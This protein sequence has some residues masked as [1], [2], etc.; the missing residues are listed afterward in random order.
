VL[1]DRRLS[2]YASWF[3]NRFRQFPEVRVCRLFP[4]GLAIRGLE[5]GSAGALLSLP[6][7]RDDID[8]RLAETFSR[9]EAE[10]FESG[11]A[12]LREERYRAARTALFRGLEAI[13]TTAER[14][15]ETAE[16]AL[17]RLPPAAERQHLL[18]VLDANLT[19]IS[20]SEVKEVAGFL[21]PPSEE[22]AGETPVGPGKDAPFRSYL[23]ASAKLYRALAEAAGYNLRELT[24]ANS[25]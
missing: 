7:R 19:A 18:A 4:G 6:D 23:G 25:E 3:E 22:E 10:F 17:N 8:R 14:G 15:A 24:R 9:V 2:L 5:A 11:A 13:K 12:R 20:E 21:F 1:T 16:Q